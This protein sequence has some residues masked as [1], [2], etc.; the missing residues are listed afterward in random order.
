MITLYEFPLSGNC[1][2]VRLLLS[3][4]NLDYRSI[5]VNGNE[6]QQKSAEFIKLNP[7]GQVPVLTDGNFTIRDSQAILV[8]LAKKYDED[9]WLSTD[10]EGLAEIVSWLSTASN[11]VALGPNRLRLHY[12]FGRAIDVE[13]AQQTT[14]VLFDILEQHLKKNNWLATGRVT[15]ADVA[16]YPYVA[17]AS[18]GKFNLQPYTAIGRWM[19]RIKALPGYV[20][21]PGMS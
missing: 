15:I 18:E 11:E 17:L 16:I 2:K 13:A 21:M 7:F 3:L 4:L 12:K 6:K 14:L 9:H 10:A 1:H 20:S 19:D 5:Q 8:Y